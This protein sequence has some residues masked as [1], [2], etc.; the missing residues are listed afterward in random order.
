MT[1]L[2][3]ASPSFSR[4]EKLRA[5]ILS[6]C[7]D[8]RF[9]DRDSIHSRADLIQFLEGC[10]GAVVG[11]HAIDEDVLKA[12][13]SL[14]ILS[15]YGVGL[16]NIPVDLCKEYGVQVGWTG[17]VNRVSVAEQTL[18]FIISLV[19]NL[20]IG[21]D[22]NKRGVWKKNG[23]RQLS[24]LTIGIIGFGYIGQQLNTFLRS[25]GCRVVV[26]DILDQGD[27]YCQEGVERMSV[28]D[29]LAS[30]DVVTMHADLNDAS[31]KMANA[32]MF[33]L[34]KESA[35]FINTSR[36]EVVDQQALKQALIKGEVAGAAL[37]VYEVEP[38]TDLEFLT[39]PN[40]ICTPHISG[41]SGAA[42]EAMGM[43]AIEHLKRY[44]AGHDSMVE[45]GVVVS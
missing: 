28:N 4:S 34:M 32:E 40:V 3:V 11:L 42:I 7:D 25:F 29:L 43:S 21:S 23:G 22:N 6:V 35:Y 20:Y 14:K 10:D 31:Y 18:G 24:E 9:N 16:N 44:F 19:R 39:M 37:D 26:N 8:V 17:G 27:L 1:K 15:K 36:G 33:K 5:A 38:P 13:P 45:A 30:S 2:A 41:N 12:L